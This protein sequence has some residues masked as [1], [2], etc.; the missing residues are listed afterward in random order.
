M[1]SRI[2][3]IMVSTSRACCSISARSLLAFGAMSGTTNVAIS[4]V[5]TMTPHARKMM[6]S[7]WGKRTSGV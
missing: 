1:T 2:I 5:H 6:S 3:W 4:S 7:R